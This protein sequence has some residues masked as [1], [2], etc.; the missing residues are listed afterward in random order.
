MKV[1][2]SSQVRSLRNIR[3]VAV[4]IILS[5][6]FTIPHTG[7]N[8]AA[9]DDAVR[10]N[11]VNI[12]AEGEAGKWVLAGGSDI[13]CIAMASD[14]TLYASV[15]N[16]DYTLY[17]S[18]DATIYYA[19]T[20]NV[21]RSTDD[22]I[23]FYPLSSNPG[24]AGT[25]DV[26]ITSIDVTRY[27]SNI[28]AL[29]TR[30]T[31]AGE[32]GEVYILDEASPFSGWTPT[33]IGNYDVCDVAFS[34]SYYIDFQLIAVVTNETD[35][36]TACRNGSM[37]WNA[38][39]GLIRLGK[40]NT[41]EPVMATGAVIAFPDNYNAS[42]IPINYA[43]YVGINTGCGEGDVYRVEC[44]IEPHARA[45]DLNIGHVYGLGN[46]DITG[47]TAAGAYPNLN[48][49][50]GAADNSRI[51]ISTDGG[52][53]WETNSKGP[54]G[55]TGTCILMAPDFTTTGMAYATSSGPGSAF[56]VSRDG[57]NT[58]NQSSLIDDTVITIVDMAPSP[59]YDDDA[60]L[61]MITFGNGHSLWRSTSGGNNWER[62]LSTQ[63]N[64]IDT[65]N[66]VGLPPQY[67]DGCRT[68][69]I[70]GDSNGQPVIWKTTDDGQNYRCHGNQDP[71]TGMAFGVDTWAIAD[72]N[73]LFA[74]GYNG[75]NGIV[76]KTI[77]SGFFY[78]QAA[79]AGNQPLHSIVLSPD[80]QQDGTILVGNTNGGVYWSENDGAYFQVLPPGGETQQL[81]GTISVAFDPGFAR[82]RTVYATS[83]TADSGIYR[84]VIGE[85]S[86]WERI[87]GTLAAGT[88]FSQITIS[89][90]G[91]LYASNSKNGGGM[92]RCLKAVTASGTSFETITSGLEENSS[93]GGLWQCGNRLW[94]IDT[95]NN[96]LLTF[97][98]T[99][100]VPVIL[101]KPENMG[102]GVGNVVD[103]K[104]RNVTIEWEKVEGA[105]RYKWRCDDDSDFSSIPDGLED[106][107]SASSA[108][109]PVLEPATTYYWQVRASSPVAGPWS[110][111]RSFTTT[112][113]AENSPVKLEIPYAGASDVPI[114]PVF[115]WN[116]IDKSNA[117]EL[118]V[119]PN[120]DFTNTVIAKQGESALISNAWQC[121]VLL[122][123][124]TT[125]YW[126][127]RAI[128]ASTSSRWSATG[129][130]TTE[131]LPPVETEN[132]TTENEEPLPLQMPEMTPA[133]IYTQQKTLSPE[134]QVQP[135]ALPTGS[136]QVTPTPYASQSLI[137]Q[138]WTIY[139]IAGLVATI[140]FALIVILV[141]TLKMRRL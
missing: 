30:D 6:I 111:K 64:E 3:Y 108:R 73:T 127:V 74:G 97:D 63:M 19:T 56:S 54:T 140:I 120:A 96:L 84:F 35:T 75:T 67:G 106:T 118:L 87:T 121:D 119:S 49:L 86:E 100:T 90:S 72:D 126:K 41:S 59:H 133:S 47:L 81:A 27:E 105:T 102:P 88:T 114:R 68:L 26:E 42:S 123:N 16:L 99:L 40:D 61:F 2:D 130:F 85:S 46:I 89:N 57:G 136:P 39:T 55:E 124:D 110:E 52:A 98:D 132:Q 122:D 91:V 36:F 44:N 103:N 135:Q 80:Y 45:S 101:V 58:W 117:Y 77:N 115:Q 18:R 31:G 62:I 79:P 7:D 70:T 125:Y 92:E 11:R 137:V 69:F 21:Y 5:A 25:N 66:R 48:L 23:N 10:W 32:F 34:P 51:Y 33:N 13:R 134:I 29:G 83:D 109:L 8:A 1:L 131:M 37:E 17:R 93:L 15:S 50:A 38:M 60:M 4:L 129:A 82:N 76:Y 78:S 71:A 112:M 14:G 28:I 94:S 43:C 116:T 22:G 20:S 24:Q 139:L 104:I 12:P 65:I 107:T 9:D 128:S 95:V 113:A 138:K 53:N 141:M